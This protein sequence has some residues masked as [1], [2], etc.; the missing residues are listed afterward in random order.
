MT[1]VGGKDLDAEVQ[2]KP[3]EKKAPAPKRPK[4]SSKN[5]V[6]EGQTNIF[7]LLMDME[8]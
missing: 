7:D 4:K 8:K 6:P 3:K 1:F 5:T 2:E